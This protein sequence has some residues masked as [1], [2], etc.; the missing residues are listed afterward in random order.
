MGGSTSACVGQNTPLYLAMAD[1]AI[2]GFIGLLQLGVLLVGAAHHNSQRVVWQRPLQ[3]LCLVPWCAHPDVALFV[4]PQDHGHGLRLD[5][6]DDS[7]RRC[8]HSSSLLLNFS[9]LVTPRFGSTRFSLGTSNIVGQC[10]QAFAPA[11][12][13]EHGVVAYRC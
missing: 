1:C 4:C 8:R 10:D 9:V 6:F 5:R 11:S 13:S 12:G 3:R 7:V 2:R